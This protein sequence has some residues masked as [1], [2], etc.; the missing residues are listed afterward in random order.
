[1]PSLVRSLKPCHSA[2][3]TGTEGLAV[4]A[5]APGSDCLLPCRDIEWDQGSIGT[6]EPLLAVSFPAETSLGPFAQT[7]QAAHML[8]KVLAHTDRRK[9]NSGQDA[10]GLLV[11]ALQLHKALLALDTSFNPPGMHSTNW[12]PSPE[13]P[14]G[15][16]G[17]EDGGNQCA[18]ALCSSA[19]LLLYSEYACD[20]FTGRMPNRE[21]VAL[22]SEAQGVAIRGIELM[23]T[24][25][26][27]RMAQAVV[28]ASAG[29]AT[30]PSINPLL[31]H[32]MYYAA[33]ECACFIKESHGRDMHT[34]LA[35]IVQGL[36][37]MRLEWQ[38]GGTC[39]I[40]SACLF[41]PMPGL[42]D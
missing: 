13:T 10:A 12:Y 14:M 20:D 3:S 15:G 40:F 26:I 28:Q 31:G 32:A 19:R 11:E 18:T 42:T 7:C 37:A 23:A 17:V 39:C 5:P 4:A 6:N 16:E 9:H 22:E 33:T 27:P 8:D 36:E 1:M 21:R 35:Q 24:V 2:I 30:R 29:A 25:T 41:R 38:V 34:A